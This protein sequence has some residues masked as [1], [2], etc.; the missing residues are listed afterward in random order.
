MKPKRR[1]FE[2]VSDIQKKLQAVLDSTN[3]SDFQ[4]HGKNY[5]ITAYVPKETI[6]K[7]MAAKIK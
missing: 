3:E 6:L 7:V 5:Q 2:A 4:G 1:R